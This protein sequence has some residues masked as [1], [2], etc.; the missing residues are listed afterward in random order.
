MPDDTA[1][2]ALQ[3]RIIDAYILFGRYDSAEA[4][5][6]KA[7]LLSQK[8]HDTDGLAS[9]ICYK[10]IIQYN[11]SRYENSIASLDSAGRL[12][13][14]VKNVAG[15]IRTIN[16]KA[17]ALAAL[18]K[19]GNA[20]ALLDTAGR[21]AAE[22]GNEKELAHALYLRGSILNDRGDYIGA[23]TVLQ[24]SLDI[25]IAI[26][27]TA[28]MGASYAFLGLNYSC[29][30]D[31]TR[32]LDYIQKSILIRQQINDKRGLAN[33][34]LS[35]YKILYVMKEWQRA[36]GSEFKS[37]ALCSEIKDEQ[38]VSGRYT[39]IGALYLRLGE[40]EKALDYHFKALAISRRIGIRDREALVLNNI[41]KTYLEL[42]RE[43]SA[44][45][46]IDSS[47][48]IRREIND[49]EGVSDS[50]LTLAHVYYQTGAY[51]QS[52]AT[53]QKCLA[54]KIQQPG[55]ETS[56]QAYQLLSNSYVKLNDYKNA[57]L[58]YSRYIAVR[59]R[60]YNIETSKEL[61]KKQ[62]NFEFSQQQQ[63]QRLRQEKKDVLAAEQLR[64][65]Q[66]IRN[67]L[68]IGFVL[69]ALI[70]FLLF[71]AFNQKK[72]SNEKLRLVNMTL[73]QQRDRLEVQNTQIEYQHRL[74]GIKNKEITDS[75]FYA[76][77]IQ[78][79]LLPSKTDFE[80]YFDDSF[81]LFKPKDI[82]SGDFYWI[83]EK[84]GRIILVTADCTGHGVPGGFMSML[85]IS[86][87]NEIINE[88]ALTEP[89]LVMSKLRKKVITSLRQKG[90]SG[91]HQDGMDL[92]LMVIDKKNSGMVY[93]TANHT[94]YLLRKNDKGNY[95]LKQYRG[96][97]QPVGIYGE[98][99]RPFSQAAVELQK[100]DLIYTFSDGY[101]DQFGGLQGK[102]FKYRQLQQV[103]L[104]IAHLPMA[105]QQQMLDKI[106]LSWQGNMEQVDD[107]VVIGI[108][109]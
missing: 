16:N 92:T 105:E 82:I 51:A 74:I 44:L 35:Q 106:L 60:I 39:N 42:H 85:G 69:I 36:L 12:F 20:L 108:K 78:T 100:G 6:N 101:A 3:L 91:E 27:D 98:K 40:Y 43:A 8:I 99:L 49:P 48:A 28:G 33:A 68:L 70:L 67:G 65:Q 45:L 32:A 59:D 31:Y 30:G 62:L 58:N 38:C 11:Q 1:K 107:I 17:K 26:K 46:Y 22:T 52:I 90:I 86:L 18:D 73:Q 79:S 56:L 29:L 109:I 21:K 61:T 103:L 14:S 66:Y 13:V 81:I 83:S 97:K 53:A 47:L 80:K 95:E 19:Y 88:Y 34:F 2:V 87:L 102:K 84:E 4:E 23:G 75:I 54:E 63:M 77:N 9:A 10:G 64:R 104:Q 72:E 94:F 93:S 89:A 7:R 24:K 37:L 5:I 50:Y 96:D 76:K 57:F 25:R 15:E 71:R 41:A 55:S